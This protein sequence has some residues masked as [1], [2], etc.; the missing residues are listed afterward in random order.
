MSKC[1]H[2]LRFHADIDLEGVGQTQ[3][4]AVQAGSLCVPERTKL[5]ISEPLDL[6]PAVLSGK[7]SSFWLYIWILLVIRLSNSRSLPQKIHPD[8]PIETEHPPSQLVSSALL[9]L[10]CS[11]P[12]S[13]YE[14][15]LP[16]VW[17]VSLD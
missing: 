11:W 8:D 7:S 4:N 15:I 14:N 16:R 6:V 9:I 5:F 3:I 12:V 10:I 2:I 17:S 1:G 13:V